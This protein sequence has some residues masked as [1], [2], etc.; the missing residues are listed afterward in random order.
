MIV[1]FLPEYRYIF[2]PNIIKVTCSDTTN[3]T[4]EITLT[5]NGIALKR[6]CIASVAYFDLSVI[7]ES[8]FSGSYFKIE[9]S[10]PY[11]DPFYKDCLISLSA[12]GETSIINQHF[13]LRWGACQFD[14][15]E[16]E[17]IKFPYWPGLPFA[18]NCDKSYNLFNQI[19]GGL[20]GITGK[21]IPFTSTVVFSFDF[22]TDSAHEQTLTFYPETNINGH[23]LRWSDAHGKLFHYMFYKNRDTLYQKDIKT[24]LEIPVY[25]S[26]LT[27]SE[28]GRSKIISKS[29]QRTF[30]A[31]TSCDSDIYPYV[32]SIASSLIVAMYV[33]NKW[34]GVKISD[35]K[36]QPKNDYLI[37]MEFIIE[38]PKDFIQTR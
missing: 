7:F 9:Y 37:D 36:T 20:S 5:S 11:A 18:F 31:F 28:G 27:D 17:S 6:N 33:N 25:P 29:V 12:T 30:S 1:A 21:M 16:I 10:E 22:W 3:P 26:S 4:K 15:A 8:Y 2:N 34:V 38:M 32:E 35:M 19:G 13:S 14:E 24:S 23:Y